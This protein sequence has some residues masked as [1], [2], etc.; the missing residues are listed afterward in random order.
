MIVYERSEIELIDT[1]ITETTHTVITVDG[2]DILPADS[3]LADR[4]ITPRTRARIVDGVPPNT[5]RAYTRQ[6]EAWQAWC[7]RTGRTPLP[8][9]GETLAEYTAT[10]VDTGQAPA[11]IEQ[12][13]AAVRTAHREAGHPGQPDTR[14][15]RLVL[16]S[17]RREHAE[18]GTRTR[19]APPVTIDVLRR[20]IDVCDIATPAGLRDRVLLVVGFALM[21]RR[22]EIAALALHDVAETPDGLLITIRM[23]KTDQDARGQTVAVPH[24]Q[25]GGTDPV[26]LVRAWRSLLTS[27]G[28]TAGPFLRRID[29]HSAIHGGLS[30]AA[31]NERVRVLAVRAGIPDAER[32]TAHSLRA[33]GA[34]AAYRAGAPVS[35]IAAHGRWTPASPVVLGYIRAVDQWQDNPMRGVGL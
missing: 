23:S 15:A 26:R 29:R 22:S 35:T 8:A 34:T 3:P 25:H 13:I 11:S 6:W 9:T 1:S 19:Q 33:G 12:A 4:I 5:R 30:G 10:L 20:M 31:I 18:R 24:G 28:V 32:F 14:G 7:E 16:R 17:A 2:V 21:G 27:R